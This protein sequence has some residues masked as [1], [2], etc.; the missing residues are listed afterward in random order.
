MEKQLELFKLY[1]RCLI[2]A[3]N[4]IQHGWLVPKIETVLCVIKYDVN[5]LSLNDNDW[6]LKFLNGELDC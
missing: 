6:A 1:T 3:K 2:K 5:T 4:E